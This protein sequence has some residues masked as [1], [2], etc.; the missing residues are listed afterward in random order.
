[1]VY[2]RKK[3]APNAVATQSDF[4]QARANTENPYANWTVPG[5]SITGFE[6]RTH[7]Q[8]PYKLPCAAPLIELV[9]TVQKVVNS[10]P[11][12]EADLDLYISDWKRDVDAE[13]RW[14]G[15][16]KERYHYRNHR[17]PILAPGE[18]TEVIAH[19]VNGTHSSSCQQRFE[20]KPSIQCGG[21]SMVAVPASESACPTNSL[22][23]Q[24]NPSR[25][26]FWT[27]S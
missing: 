4:L 12:L 14:A 3:N 24:L 19:T 27:S 10:T 23:R 15:K 18:R 17:I 20:R 7:P 11:P 26:H 5:Y 9:V 13:Y 8:A 21:R 16:Y 1:M 6:V 25:S 22:R 2:G